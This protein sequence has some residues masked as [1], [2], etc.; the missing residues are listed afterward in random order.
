M[1]QLIQ[2]LNIFAKYIGDSEKPISCESDTLFVNCDPKLV[3][4][5]DK[6]LLSELGFDDNGY[7]F[8]ADKCV[9]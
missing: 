4:N 7:F 2:A 6:S 5:E 9:Y 8:F 3:S 1:K